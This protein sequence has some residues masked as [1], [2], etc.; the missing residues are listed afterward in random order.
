MTEQQ[1]KVTLRQRKKIDQAFQSNIERFI[2][3]DQC[4]AMQNDV[5]MFGDA[6]FTRDSSPKENAPKE[7][8]KSS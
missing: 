5:R 7:S 3:S 2:G 6:A 4:V 8:R 1:S